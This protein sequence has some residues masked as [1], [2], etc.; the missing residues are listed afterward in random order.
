MKTTAVHAGLANG[1]G[2]RGTLAREAGQGVV[3]RCSVPENVTAGTSP[4]AGHCYTVLVCQ[5]T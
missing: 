1:K 4:A 5:Y 2:M 3:D